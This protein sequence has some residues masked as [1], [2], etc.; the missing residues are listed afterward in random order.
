MEYGRCRIFEAERNVNAMLVESDC[1][2]YFTHRRRIYVRGMFSREDQLL[3]MFCRP[4]A[5]K[6]EILAGSPH[7]SHPVKRKSPHA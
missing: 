2:L 4:P 5:A 1:T 3:N 6:A 7:N